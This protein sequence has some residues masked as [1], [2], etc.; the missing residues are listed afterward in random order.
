MQIDGPIPFTAAQAYRMQPATHV[1]KEAPVA[2]VQQLIAGQVQGAVSFDGIAVND[3]QPL[4]LYTRCADRIEVATRIATGQH[5]NI[6][7]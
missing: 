6:Q 2:P 3:L 7:A 1:V 4:Q 5:L